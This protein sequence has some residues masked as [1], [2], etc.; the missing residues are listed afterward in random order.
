MFRISCL[1]LAAVKPRHGEITFIPNNMEH[2]SSFAI[3][4]VT[5]IDLCQFMLSSLNELSSN[6]SKNQF[7]ENR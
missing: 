2:C 3:N 1:M 5:F 7:R 4:I 6:F